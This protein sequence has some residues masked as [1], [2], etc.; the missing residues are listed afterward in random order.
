MYSNQ[1]IPAPFSGRG[2]RACRTGEGAPQASPAPVLS[3]RAEPAPTP[4]PSS[5]SIRSAE[6]PCVPRQANCGI[7]LPLFLLLWALLTEGGAAKS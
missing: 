4:M 1:S 2:G 5:T 7:S 6:Q 3:Q